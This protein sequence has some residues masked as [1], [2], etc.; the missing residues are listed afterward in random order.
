M[1]KVVLLLLFLLLACTEEGKHAASKQE[2]TTKTSN[3]HIGVP[4]F[5]KFT[6]RLNPKE[7]QN[8]T[9]KS[10]IE[11]NI[12]QTIDTMQVR[13]YHNQTFVYSFQTKE[14]NPTEGVTFDV[15]FRSIQQKLQTPV[16][17]IY[18]NTDNKVSQSNP[19][20]FFYRSLIGKGF[21][22][23]VKN[24]GKEVK[25]FGIDSLA[26]SV[27]RTLENKR[28]SEIELNGLKQMTQE[29]FNPEEMKKNFEK[30]F[31]IFPDSAISKNS[32]WKIVKTVTQPIPAQVINV[33]TLDDVSIDTVLISVYSKIIFTKPSK[34]TPNQPN[35]KNMSG[36]QTGSLKLDKNTG[37]T[38][39]GK[40]AQSINIEYEL[41]AS[42]QTNNKSMK[43]PMNIK[44]N[45]LFELTNDKK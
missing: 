24:N 30:T 2:D 33:Y 6:L 16:L 40:F 5:D 9:Y 20:E 31:E 38:L 18:A 28:L 15:F 34:T 26:Q 23:K 10:T 11:Q 19:L 8:Y 14:N 27:Y 17:T 42:P 39:F 41:P 7:G 29:F 25:L 36:N 4:S 35:I 12:L 37:M 32:K 44:T 22:I 45:F 13:T 43:I 21:K 3:A 1:K